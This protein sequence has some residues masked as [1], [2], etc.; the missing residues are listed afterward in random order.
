MTVATIVVRD[1]A[2]ELSTTCGN[3]APKKVLQLS[4]MV[5]GPNLVY[6][7]LFLRNCKREVLYCTY[8]TEALAWHAFW[9]NFWASRHWNQVMTNIC[10]V[11]TQYKKGKKLMQNQYALWLTYILLVCKMQLRANSSL[12]HL[13]KH[14]KEA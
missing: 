13:Q 11:P 6:K 7:I 14:I 12:L 10:I 8:R 4:V 9:E 2:H 1:D 3:F 5:S